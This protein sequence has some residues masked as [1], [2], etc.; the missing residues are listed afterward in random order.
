MTLRERLAAE[1]EAAHRA[2][3]AARGRARR[4]LLERILAERRQTLAHYDAW[5]RDGERAKAHFL[6]QAA[7]F[8]R[9][10][11]RDAADEYAL[12]REHDANSAHA[13]QLEWGDW[14]GMSAEGNLEAALV[15][16]GI[17]PQ[18]GQTRVLAERHGLRN[19]RHW[20]EDLRQE[21]ARLEAEL[22][23]LKL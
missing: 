11:A 23:A 9:A 2:A 20:R 13:A 5:L 19:T 8:D 18:E 6:A 22:A 4:G 15:E 14:S 10:K 7:K 17:A 16:L 21:I 3:I 1:D 12:A